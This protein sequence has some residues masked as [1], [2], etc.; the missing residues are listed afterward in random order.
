MSQNQKTCLDEETSARDASNESDWCNEC[1]I[2]FY[3]L[4]L[5]DVET[6]L[7]EAKSRKSNRTTLFLERH[8]PFFEKQV[9]VILLQRH[10][11]NWGYST[12]NPCYPIDA[13][14]LAEQYVW[15]TYDTVIGTTLH[16][17]DEIAEIFFLR[18]L[19]W[20]AQLLESVAD[21]VEKTYDSPSSYQ[22]HKQKLIFWQGN[23]KKHEKK[24]AKWFEGTSRIEFISKQ[25]DTIINPSGTY[26]STA[27]KYNAKNRRRFAVWVPSWKAEVTLLK[28]MINHLARSKR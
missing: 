11:D 2:K 12:E 4:A 7:A 17:I 15:T 9:Q 26:R 25:R 3:K 1:K 13:Y 28:G 27:S 19:R 23:F 10:P 14:L 18:D 22:S 16:P 6:T 5:Q 21:V 24:P 8:W 20:F